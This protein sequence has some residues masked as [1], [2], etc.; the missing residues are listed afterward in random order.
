M[1]VIKEIEDKLIDFRHILHRH[2]EQSNNESK[3]VQRLKEF[4]CKY[5]PDEVIENLGGEGIIFLFKGN[6]P[7]KKPG[8]TVLIR[9]ELDALPL[10]EVND[11]DYVSREKNTAHLCGHD[12]HMTIVSGIAP[13]LNQ[14]RNYEGTVGLLFQPAE[15]TGEGAQRILDDERFKALNADY[16]FALHN[17]PGAPEGTVILKSGIF[18]MAS[19][20][21][22]VSLYGRSTHAAHPE[23]GISPGKA[24]AKI[25]LG[26]DEVN[27][28]NDYS[29]LAFATVI[30]SRL[31]DEAFGTQPGAGKLM[32]TLRA[33]DDKDIELLKQNL[34]KLA[35]SICAEEN[36]KCTIGFTEEFKA[37]VNDPEA[38][39]I[40]RSAAEETAQDIHQIK[41]PFRWS[42]DFG[43][44]TAEIKGAMFGL[45]AGGDQPELHNPDYDF[46]DKLISYGCDIFYRII[47]DLLHIQKIGN[48]TEYKQD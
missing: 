20:G 42:E 48:T 21:M 6:K 17:I 35:D 12:G 16:I 1:S 22:I 25:I 38:V 2:P 19:V 33:E 24:I 43:R 7:G 4:I 29:G 5:S 28:S 45:G 8:K 10:K 18:A 36:L 27:S 13:L 30:H 15:E 46:P 32:F 47:N 37:T 26:V 14:N 34:I 23:N 44:F 11:V 39:D 41:K 40:I 9:A 3:T 31:G